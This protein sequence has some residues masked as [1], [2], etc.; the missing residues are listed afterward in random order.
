MC[1]VALGVAL[2]H[3][4]D[5]AFVEC[6]CNMG[7]TPRK[8]LKLGMILKY[9]KHSE[10][11]NAPPVFSPSKTLS[12]RGFAGGIEAKMIVKLEPLGMKKSCL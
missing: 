10:D 4:C 11:Q 12:K 7:I 3:A 2:G 5:L 9:S 6:W 8:G 1:S